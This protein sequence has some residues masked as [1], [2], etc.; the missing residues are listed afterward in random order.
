MPKCV[1]AGIISQVFPLHDTESL[2]RLQKSWVRAIFKRQPLG[3]W[4]IVYN[5]KKNN[6]R[7]KWTFV[8]IEIKTFNTVKKSLNQCRDCETNDYFSL[9]LIFLQIESVN[10]SGWR[11]QC[12][13]PGWATTRRRSSC[14]PS[15]DLFFGWVC[16]CHFPSRGLNQSAHIN[17][18][19]RRLPRRC[20]LISGNLLSDALAP[21]RLHN[22]QTDSRRRRRD[23]L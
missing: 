12:T 7:S 15:L 18:E 16:F 10:T 4:K 2:S 22:Q 3:K 6:H 8:C 11:S 14:P 1:S 5:L 23:D 17:T 13:S 9:M 21:N 20:R 19:R